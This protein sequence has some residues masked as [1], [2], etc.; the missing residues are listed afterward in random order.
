VRFLHESEVRS[1]LQRYGITP[2]RDKGQ[3]FLT[4]ESI[5]KTIVASASI[6]KQETVLEIGGGLGILS[7]ALSGDARHLYII[8]IEEG[9]VRALKDRL[10]DCGNVTILHQDALIAE[11]PSV[12]KVVSNLPYSVA[13]EITFRLL[14]VCPFELAVMMYQKEFA[15]RLLARPGTQEYSR[16]SID[17]QYLGV[18]KIIMDVKAAEFFPVPQVDSSVLA[19]KRR[20]TGAFARDPT[21]FFWMVNG[22]Y[23]YPNK[24]LRRALQIWLKLIGKADLADALLGALPDPL[25]GALRLRCLSIEHLVMLADVI[26]DFVDDEKLT[27]PRR[28]NNRPQ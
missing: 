18:A 5:A 11:I 19:I 23:S 12:D 24:Q 4:S 6:T 26:T 20:T 7:K 1:L 2:S 25:H 14:E 13:S 8:E 28:D 9:L 22:L 27:G 16:L 3:I 21:H 17:F 15:S 10:R